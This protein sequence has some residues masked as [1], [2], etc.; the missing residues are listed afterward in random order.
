MRFW[1]ADKTT[2]SWA[3]SMNSSIHVFQALFLPPPSL[4]YDSRISSFSS[5]A[6]GSL[7]PIRKQQPLSGG[8]KLLLHR[9]GIYFSSF[10]L[11]K[12]FFPLTSYHPA[13]PPF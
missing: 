11:L 7:K 4:I 10:R 5:K 1:V 8:K 2:T 9:P 12:I 3:F 6:A 13:F